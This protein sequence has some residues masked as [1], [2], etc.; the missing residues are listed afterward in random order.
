[1]YKALAEKLYQKAAKDKPPFFMLVPWPFWF[2]DFAGF[3][4]GPLVFVRDKKDISLIVHE[5]VHVRQFY[6][7]PIRFPILYLYHLFKVGY[8]NNP[9]E[10]AAR[11]T[12][13]KAE[14][15]LE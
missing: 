6:D 15:I 8:Q 1:M 9:Y 14:R 10:V 2:S 5:M 7:A 11:K 12:Q 4:F 3:S 13:K